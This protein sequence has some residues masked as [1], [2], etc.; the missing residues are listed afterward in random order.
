MVFNIVVMWIW[1]CK[2]VNDG[3]GGDCSG[4]IGGDCGGECDSDSRD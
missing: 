4:D 3:H 1:H 2:G